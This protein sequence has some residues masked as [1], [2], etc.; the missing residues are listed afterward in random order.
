MTFLIQSDNITAETGTVSELINEYNWL[1]EGRGQIDVEF[2]SFKSLIEKPDSQLNKS[3]IP[4]GSIEFS[5]AFFRKTTGVPHF[6]PILVPQE[7]SAHTHRHTAICKSK[8]E[9]LNLFS[10]WNQ[11]VLFIKS[12]SRRKCDYT[13]TY[14]LTDMNSLPDDEL[15][16]VSEPIYILSEWRVFVYNGKIMDIRN[17]DGDFWLMPDKKTVEEM[18]SEYSYVGDYLRGTAKNG[19]NPPAYTL[20]VAVI[21]KDGERKTAVVEVHN[22]ISCGMYGFNHPKLL[23]MLKCGWE[24][25]KKRA[26]QLK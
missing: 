2:C 19:E 10:E 17:Y 21:E 5:E 15:Y 3:Y 9:I 6:K 26:F 23:Q 8:Q 20:D 7:L 1:H 22:F 16:F 12:A 13:D 14:T 4:V 25:E 11:T 18:V 24:W